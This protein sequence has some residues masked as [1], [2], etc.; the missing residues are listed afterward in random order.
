MTH[1]DEPRPLLERSLAVQK[2]LQ[3]MLI[4]HMRVDL[5]GNGRPARSVAAQCCGNP[6]I[7]DLVSK[8]LARFRWDAAYVA[9]LQSRLSTECPA[10]GHGA[11]CRNLFELLCAHVIDCCTST[12]QAALFSVASLQSFIPISLAHDLIGEA[13]ASNS[14]G[15]NA[16][17]DQVFQKFCAIPFC[18]DQR[19]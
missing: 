4:Q 13:H 15:I 1:A 18:K 2:L 19:V 16:L 9:D 17:E 3:A 7:L 5:L 10:T 8:H 14:N 11:H 12:E 6:G